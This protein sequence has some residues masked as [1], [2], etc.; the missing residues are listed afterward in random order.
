MAQVHPANYLVEVHLA[1][2]GWTAGGA[3]RPLPQAHTPSGHRAPC[4]PTSASA[5]FPHSFFADPFLPQYVPMGAREKGER[6]SLRVLKLFRSKKLG[7]E[8]P[9]GG[10]PMAFRLGRRSTSPPSPAGLD[11]IHRLY[12]AERLMVAHVRGT[13]AGSVEISPNA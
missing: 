4:A 12:Q 6:G 7:M 2:H 13:N 11:E 1:P 5:R 10:E 3:C 9:G 8:I